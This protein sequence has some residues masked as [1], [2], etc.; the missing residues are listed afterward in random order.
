MQLTEEYDDYESCEDGDHVFVGRD[1]ICEKCGMEIHDWRS[2][3]DK[4]DDER[5]YYVCE[6]CGECED[7][8]IYPEDECFGG[9]VSED[10]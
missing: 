5:T 8:I 1:C 3:T 4:Y 6:R 7:D 9:D 2:K 10:L